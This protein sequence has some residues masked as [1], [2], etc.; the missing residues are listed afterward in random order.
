MEKKHLRLNK[1]L[2]DALSP[3]E[4]KHMLLRLNLDGVRLRTYGEI[5][6]AMGSSVQ[7]VSFIIKNAQKKL[8]NNHDL[9]DFLGAY[10]SHY[11]DE[12]QD[13][14]K[15]NLFT[16]DISSIVCDFIID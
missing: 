6:E 14:E 13:H 1:I 8:R 5:A 15:D 2:K 11:V 3:L 4:E 16:D 12:N 7:D 9:K 10:Y